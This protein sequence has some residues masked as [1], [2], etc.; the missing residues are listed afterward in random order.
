[1]A[2]RSIGQIA[3]LSNE[4]LTAIVEEDER[5]ESKIL[6][7]TEWK[8][9]H[10]ISPKSKSAAD[11]VAEPNSL[12]VHA[13]MDAIERLD[14]HDLE[15]ALLR[16]KVALGRQGLIF[17]VLDPCWRRSAYLGSA[18]TLRVA[19]EHLASAF[20]RTF[21]GDFLGGF[22]P[23]ESSPQVIVTTQA[24]QVH[25]FGALLAASTAASAGYQVVYLGP[26]LPAEEV[27]TAALQTNARAVALSLVYPPDDPRI[28]RELMNLKRQLPGEVAIAVG[29]RASEN[30]RN[31]LDAIGAVRIQ[32]FSEF[33]EFLD[34]FR[35]SP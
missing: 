18:G 9:E 26:N 3:H 25:E 17:R 11:D 24:G 30:Y 12:Y 31:T 16:A 35:N 32:R 34:G 22:E 7:E 20:F 8:R 33:R 21:L 23:S 14:T 2:G 15:E 19:H 10:G 6:L 27:S 5:A 4:E 13:C 1:M 28:D 29:G